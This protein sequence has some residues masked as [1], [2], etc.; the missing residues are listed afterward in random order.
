MREILLK[1]TTKKI[2]SQ[3]VG[4]FNFLG[5]SIKVGLPLV[6]NILIPLAKSV[7]V[8]LGLPAAASATDATIQK[9]IFGS[10][11]TLIIFGEINYIIKIVQSLESSG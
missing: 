7:L 5:L 2:T 11:T 3:K 4:L 1:G 10:G 8:P 9:K 6:K